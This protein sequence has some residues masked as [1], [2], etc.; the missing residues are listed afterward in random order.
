MTDFKKRIKD[1]LPFFVKNQGYRRLLEILQI[2]DTGSGLVR[3]TLNSS[4]RRKTSKK[5][6]VQLGILSIIM[7]SQPAWPCFYQA[8][9]TYHVPAALLKAIAV[10]ES[11]NN[12]LAVNMSN[13]NGTRDI[14]LM[15]INSQ[16]LKKLEKYGISEEDLYNPCQNIIV[17]AWILRQAL[18]THGYTWQ[19]IGAYNSSKPKSNLKYAWKIFKALE[20]LK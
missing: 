7:L 1:I 3:I 11:N 17:S 9:E 18:D 10:V 5:R 14:G 4:A 16:W 13:K 12:P 19:G 8:S 2:S 6:A 20:G 15:Q